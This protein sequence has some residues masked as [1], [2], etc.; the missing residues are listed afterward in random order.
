MA[1]A[2]A[3]AFV[4]A[5]DKFI[6]T[7]VLRAQ[8]AVSEPAKPPAPKKSAVAVSKPTAPTQ[9]VASSAAPAARNAGA[10]PLPFELLRQ[11]IEDASDEQGWAPLG[12]VGN[13]LNKIRPDFDPRLYGFKKLSDLLKSQPKHFAVEERATPGSAGKALYVRALP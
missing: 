5:C 3:D 7:E 10:L 1:V 4:Q 8:V 2:L 13:Y 11:A 9:V 6:Y 12:G